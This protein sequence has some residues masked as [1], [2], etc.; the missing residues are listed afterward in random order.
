MQLRNQYHTCESEQRNFGLMTTKRR[1]V[2]RLVYCGH[3]VHI[4]LSATSPLRTSPDTPVHAPYRAIPAP[5]AIRLSGPKPNKHQRTTCI[6][7]IQ[8]LKLQILKMLDAELVTDCSRSTASAHPHEI[9]IARVQA[10]Q[11]RA[12]LSKQFLVCI[13]PSLLKSAILRSVGY[14][15]A[16]KIVS[17]I[18][19]VV[20]IDKYKN[21]R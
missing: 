8:I 11:I 14:R 7:N 9:V 17:P 4:S 20:K 16:P 3:A 18:A 15:N 2:S 13:Y 12:P 5:S 1:T 19:A 6:Q 21:K 10:W